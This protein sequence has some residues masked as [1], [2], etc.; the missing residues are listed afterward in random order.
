[1][2][3]HQD[4]TVDILDTTAEVALIIKAIEEKLRNP[5]CFGMVSFELHFRDRKVI[6]WLVSTQESTLVTR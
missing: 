2:T 3:T 1:M 5:P 6:R 4:N